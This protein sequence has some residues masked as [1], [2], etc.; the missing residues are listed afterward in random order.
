MSDPEAFNAAMHQ[1]VKNAEADGNVILGIQPDRPETGYGYNKAILGAA[2]GMAAEVEKF[3][4]KPD[5]A[6]AQRYLAEG[7]YYWNAGMF[8]LK[9]SVW[10]KALKEFCP[11]VA[12][13][14]QAAWQNKISELSL[15]VPVKLCLRRC[16]VRRL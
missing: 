14:A 13:A 8:V 7:G 15:C 16:R 6:T 9:A 1:A 11:D 10:L 5:S 3:I 4:E 2:K 12:N